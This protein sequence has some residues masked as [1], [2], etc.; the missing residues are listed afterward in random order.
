M[1]KNRDLLP[2]TVA[3]VMLAAWGA[4]PA[5]A[6][7]FEREPI[8]Y[9]TTIPVNAVTRLQQ[10]LDSG[11]AH[12]AFDREQ[13]YLRSLL[14]ELGVR[15]SS[16]VLVFSKT[17]LQRH[18]IGPKTPRALYFS[19][20]L[21]VGY[22]R[23]GSVM[24]LSVADA[25]LGTVF[26]TLD[27]QP[28]Q[29]PRF[30]RQTDSCLLCHGSSQTRGVP[31]HLIRSVY[32]DRE[33]HPILS[34][35]SSRVEQT[36]PL[37]KRWGGWYVT[38]MHGKQTHLGNLLLNERREPEEVA[39]LGGLNVTNLADRFDTAA[40]P[41]GHSDLV[42][43][44]VLE[45]QAEMHNLITRANF[46]GRL[47]VY[48]EAALNKEL[49]RSGDYQSETTYRRIK[50]VG[51]PLLKYLLFSGEAQLTEPVRGTSDFAAEFAVR[52]P[53]DS[54]GRS[55]RE[56]DLQRRLFKYPC[57]YLIYSEAFDGLPGPVKEYVLRRLYVVLSG[58]DYTHE[59]DHLT[60]EDRQAILEILRETKRDLPDYWRQ[61]P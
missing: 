27:Q 36:T 25:K 50:S 12:L 21:Y 11:Q 57:S 37:E 56:L 45:H 26:Y 4:L 6:D 22:C 60:A 15:E 9:S 14:H 24:E 3:L 5:M 19:D 52:G 16:Q 51:E 49:G 39:K 59:Y 61:S 33:G 30:V 32:P 18:R 44:L 29:R 28:A 17:S 48:E 2:G 31:G 53:R 34:A 20:D 7:E 23:V 13:G 41:T 40:Y 8:N 47:A 58:Q 46:Q 35:G 1:A 10:R 54:R 55:L 38:G 43:L 42:A